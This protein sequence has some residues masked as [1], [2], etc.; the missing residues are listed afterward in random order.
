MRS[1]LQGAGLSS[2]V[3]HD[4]DTTE[5]VGPNMPQI[6]P[7][8][9]EVEELDAGGKVGL[10]PWEVYI[11]VHMEARYLILFKVPSKVPAACFQKPLVMLESQTLKGFMH[12]K[13]SIDLASKCGRDPVLCESLW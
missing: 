1:R 5:P 7:L 8:F 12:C 10:M 6:H 4:L 11:E 2:P 9:P 3:P 13:W